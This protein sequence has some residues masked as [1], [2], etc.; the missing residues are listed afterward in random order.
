MGENRSGGGVNF[1][2]AGEEPVRPVRTV[3]K[4][5]EDE[6]RGNKEVKKTT[7]KEKGERGA[8]QKRQK[9]VS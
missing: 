1:W 6:D 5:D 2:R 7:I 9:A 4:K 8:K 3:K